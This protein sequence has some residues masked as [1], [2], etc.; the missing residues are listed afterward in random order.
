MKL[1][2]LRTQVN[3]RKKILKQEVPVTFTHSRK[4]RP[5]NRI[6]DELA[7]FIANNSSPASVLRSPASLIGKPIK[8]RFIVEESE[9]KWFNGTII[10]YNFE[11]KLFE[12]VYEN[13][14]EHYYFDLAQDIMLGDLVIV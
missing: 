14:D 13:E 12:I 8:D 11:N 6:I 9:D 7:E 5:V 4:Q 2:L 1:K 3:I 10:D